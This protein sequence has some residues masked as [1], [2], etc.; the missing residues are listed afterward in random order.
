MDSVS[1]IVLGAAVGEAVLGKK[2]G[3][4]AA[5][6]GAI[7][8]TIPDL[9]VLSNLFMGEFDATISH[10]GITHSILFCVLA[11]PAIGWAI[12]R[13]YPIEKGT[14]QQWTWLAFWALFTHPL[15]DCF[16]TWGTQ[17]FYPFSD[18]RVAFNS[19]FVADP[20][21]TVPFGICLLVALFLKR[22]SRA[23]RVWNWLGITLSTFYL[24]IG[25]TNKLTAEAYLQNELHAQGKSVQQLRTYPTLLNTLLWYCVA[26]EPSGYEIGYYSLLGDPSQ[27]Q[28][29]YF[30]KQ[31]ENLA[32]LEDNRVVE[33]MRWMAKDQY[34]TRIKDDTLYWYDLKFG[35]LDL[36]PEDPDN[37]MPFSFVY[38]L[39]EK[40]STIVDIEAIRP[41]FRSLG[42][43]ERQL[44]WDKIWGR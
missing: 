24:I 33:G 1:Q 32:G 30:A 34:V 39:I 20:M 13:L 35:L 17:L 36:G 3:N 14:Q 27:I 25:V 43:E 42:P 28:F 29:R 26:E 9:D 4:K 2:A 10:R 6:W 31:R 5:L 11:A 18:Y 22:S 44:L 19:I 23:R 21:Y 38:K 15:L 12:R 7:C 37:P 40:D 16:T 8:G 41:D